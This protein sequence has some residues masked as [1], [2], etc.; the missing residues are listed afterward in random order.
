VAAIVGH[1]GEEEARQA[2]GRGPVAMCSYSMT[3][4][5]MEG[6]MRR[7]ALCSCWCADGAGADERVVTGKSVTYAP[8]T[9]TL[10]AYLRDVGALSLPPRSPYARPG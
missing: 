3:G 5:E 2:L 6:V 9:D 1:W 7:G 8:Q 4:A 10:P